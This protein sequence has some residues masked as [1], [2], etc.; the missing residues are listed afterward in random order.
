[1]VLCSIIILK[2]SLVYNKVF[3][4]EIILLA[5]ISIYYFFKKIN[6]QNI[7]VTSI[8]ASGF[9]ILKNQLINA[10]ILGVFSDILLVFTITYIIRLFN[11]KFRFEKKINYMIT[12]V[13]VIISTLIFVIL[14]FFSIYAMKI[15]LG[16]NSKNLFN[17]ELLAI[18]QTNIQEAYEFIITFFSFNEIFL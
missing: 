8:L 2:G 10:S 15:N 1:M 16:S 14:S 12:F 11:Y 9:I 17:D 13:L 7:G 3:Y 4:C 6:F 18:F 5:M